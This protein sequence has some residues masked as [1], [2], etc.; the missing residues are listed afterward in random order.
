MHRRQLSRVRMLALFT[1]LVALASSIGVPGAS[2]AEPTPPIG[3]MDTATAS[4]QHVFTDDFSSLAIEVDAHSGPS[5]ENPGGRV[6]FIAGTILHISG[7]VT[8]L[9]VSG[10]TAVMTVSGPFPEAPQYAAFIV[11]LVDNGGASLD[12]FEY[13]PGFADIPASLDC[14]IDPEFTVGGALDGRAV[15]TDR[16]PTPTLTTKAQC[17]ASGYLDFGFRNRGQCI[18]QLVARG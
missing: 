15:V 13:I 4:G 12:R 5:G 16:E 18:T 7:P 6:S 10:K 14:T 2:A 17:R 3:P 8:C 1:A 11:K 9:D